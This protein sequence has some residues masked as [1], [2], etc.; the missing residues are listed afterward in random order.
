MLLADKAN[1]ADWIRDRV[2]QRG[3]WAN[4]PPPSNRNGPICFSPWLYKAQHLIERFFHKLKYCQ[5]VATRYDTLATHSL[6][7]VKLPSI[8]LRLRGNEPTA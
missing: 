7:M 1:D 8:P 5:R 6:A 2:N 4:R 3:P